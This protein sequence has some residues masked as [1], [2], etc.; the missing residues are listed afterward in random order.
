MGRVGPQAA[1]CGERDVDRPVDGKSITATGA[2]LLRSSTG[3]A[4]RSC[5]S[6]LVLQAHV[7][8]SGG[9]GDEDEQAA[10]RPPPGAD[11]QAVRTESASTAARAAVAFAGN[12]G[13]FT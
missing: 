13:R 3:S 4:V 2:G 12:D 7:H 11:E 8:E 10:D 9:E 6:L 1:G 5:D